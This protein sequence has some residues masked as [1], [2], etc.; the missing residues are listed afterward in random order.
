MS[1]LQ[2]PQIRMYWDKEWRVAVIADNISRD[3]FF[4]IRNSLKIVFDNDINTEQGKAN[5]LWKIRSLIG[6]VLLGCLKQ[7][8][9]QHICLDE[10]MIPFSGTSD[11]KQYMPN[12][13]NPLVIKVF[14]LANPSGIICDFVV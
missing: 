12:K 5:R 3:R 9:N 8:K 11:L 14:V 2:L 10:M 1:C 4:Q 6:R 7:T 13:P